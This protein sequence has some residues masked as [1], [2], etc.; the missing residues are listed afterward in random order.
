MFRGGMVEAAGGKM[1]TYFDCIP[2]F[3]RQS[4]DAARALN[5]DDDKTGMLLRRTLR[6]KS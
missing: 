2:C 4:L 1:K 6:L 5:L 3:L